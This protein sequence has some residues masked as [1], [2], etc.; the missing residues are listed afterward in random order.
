MA[1]KNEIWR[2][3]ATNSDIYFGPGATEGAIIG[4]TTF[5]STAPLIMQDS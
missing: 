3:A 2:Y 5:D 1:S 4:T